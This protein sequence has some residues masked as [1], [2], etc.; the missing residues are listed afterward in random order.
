MSA[1]PITL[2]MQPTQSTAVVCARRREPII[3]ALMA[4]SYQLMHSRPDLSLNLENFAMLC[5]SQCCPSK[6]T[7]DW[8]LDWVRSLG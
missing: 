8:L 2:F 6:A 1:E 3:N 7:S 4:A 5:P